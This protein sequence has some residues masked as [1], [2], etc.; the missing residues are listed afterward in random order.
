[1]IPI[2]TGSTEATIP[3]G[4]NPY[5]SQNNYNNFIQ[6]GT[7][8]VPNNNFDFNNQP[9]VNVPSASEPTTYESTTNK[10]GLEYDIDVRFDDR[11]DNAAN[12]KTTSSP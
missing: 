8:F 2:K 10:N 5:T 7:K 9:T 4:G 11:D 3:F 12:Q 6:G 1:M